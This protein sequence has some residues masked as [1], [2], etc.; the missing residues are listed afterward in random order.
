MAIFARPASTRPGPTL[1]DRVLPSPIRNMVRYGFFKKKKTKAGPGFIKKSE[2]QPKTWPEYNSVTLKLQ[3]KPLIYIVS[4]SFV[5]PQLTPSLQCLTLVEAHSQKHTQALIL[6][7]I[8]S[9]SH[10][11]RFPQA[12]TI[13]V[14]RSHPPAWS[15]PP[16]STHSHP[17]SRTHSHL[18]T[19]PPCVS[20]STPPSMPSQHSYLS[21]LSLFT[22]RSWSE[23]S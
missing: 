8:H 14:S 9:H 21:D 20:M 11:R 12:I 3:K 18:A 2:T 15:S 7:L 13:T 5:Q 10:N 19:P 16:S 22:V 23:I 6:T 4:P 17:P 1:M